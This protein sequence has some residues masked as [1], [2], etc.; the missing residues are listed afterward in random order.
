MWVNHWK[1]N[2]KRLSNWG[3]CLPN[4]WLRKT[5]AR[6][7]RSGTPN[8]ADPGEWGWS[9]VQASRVGQMSGSSQRAQKS[10]WARHTYVFQH[11]KLAAG[12]ASIIETRLPNDTMRLM[13][14]AISTLASSYLSID[15]CKHTAHLLP[16]LFSVGKQSNS[17][18]SHFIRYY[19]MPP[20]L[21]SL[22]QPDNQSVMLEMLGTA[23]LIRSIS[24]SA[25]DRAQTKEK[26]NEPCFQEQR[27]SESVQGALHL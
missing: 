18:P 10:P 23:P 15:G 19:M 4:T 20:H 1:P 12:D 24:R 27:P 3:P 14:S 25:T 26:T 21:D 22:Q 5:P 8:P 9:C 7:A 17:G 2:E 16:P 11:K 13:N 6:A